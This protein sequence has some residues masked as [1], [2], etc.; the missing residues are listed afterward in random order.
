M[1]ETPYLKFVSHVSQF[2]VFLILVAASALRSS[3]IPSGLGENIA[4]L[5]PGTPELALCQSGQGGGG[6]QQVP[7]TGFRF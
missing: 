1:M 3:H 7:F 5:L 6:G 2:L 4:F